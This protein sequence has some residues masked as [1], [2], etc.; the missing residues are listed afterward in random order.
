MPRFLGGGPAIAAG[1][2]AAM[3]ADLAATAAGASG[4]LGMIPAAA[5]GAWFGRPTLALVGEGSRPELVIPD[6]SFKDFAANLT[7]NVLAQERQAQD[8]QSLGAGYARSATAATRNSKGIPA[9]P[10][11]APTKVE[12]HIHG[13]WLDSST[14]G[15]QQL[16]EIIQGAVSN[17][18]SQ[19]NY[20]FGADRRTIG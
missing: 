7:R 4:V 15:K 18:D 20:R 17:A 16:A 5:E 10:R 3:L 14:R 11:S 1:F 19:S 9:T 8:Y 12:V 2:N 6:T 13:H